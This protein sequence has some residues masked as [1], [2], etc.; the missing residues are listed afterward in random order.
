VRD[1]IE[2]RTSKAPP[3]ATVHKATSGSTGFPTKIAYNAESRHWRDATRWR[4]YGWAGYRP[5]M[6]AMHYWGH[7]A[8]PPTTRLGKVKLEL[9]R[10]LK[11]DHYVDCTPRSD[12]KLAEVVAAFRA[13][14]P[15]VI[16]AFAQGAAALARHV[17]RTRARTWT[18]DVPVLTGAEGLYPHDREVIE[19]AFGPVFETYGAREVM[20]MGSEC[21]AHDGLHTSMETLVIE[22]VVREPDGRYRPARPGETGEV[23]V[24]DLHN[25]AQP[26]IR[27]LIHDVA[28]ERAAA[29]CACGRWLHRIG[30]LEGRISETMRDGKGN[31]VS[32]I[33]FSIVFLNLTQHCRQFQAHQHGDGRLVIKVV[34]VDAAVGLPKAVV[35]DLHAYFAKHLPA[36]PVSI[37]YVEDIPASA[38]GKRRLVVVDPPDAPRAAA[39]SS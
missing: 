31:P 18:R 30:P 22:V 36:V 16:V 35:D 7:G 9:D 13:L 34:P 37:E 8:T 21:E 2:A 29:R 19:R 25:L 17:E 6:K 15:D 1:S 28:V 27:Y 5:G 20:L 24:T 14:E 38:A 12:E 32:G 26:M 11:R 10:A 33:I 23:C 4:A 3:F 39:A